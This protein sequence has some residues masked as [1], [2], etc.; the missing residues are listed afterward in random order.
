[1]TQESIALT[2]EEL[3]EQVWSKPVREVAAE[4]GI[5]DVGLAKACR[6]S[7]IPLPPQGYWISRHG[8]RARRLRPPLPAPKAG[9]QVHFEFH[10]RLAD[11]Q[12]D[13]LAER[14]ELERRLAALPSLD[15]L[16]PQVDR[17]VK[18]ARRAMYKRVDERGILLGSGELPW[19][20]RTSPALLERALGTL[21]GLLARLHGLGYA[22]F[23][24]RDRPDMAVVQIHGQEYWPWLEEH[25]HRSERALTAKEL[26][27]KKAAERERQYFYTPNRWVFKP[28]GH[29]TLKLDHAGHSY[30]RKQ[31][32]ERGNKKLEDKLDAIVIEI[33]E[34]ATEEKRAAELEVKRLAERQALEMQE[35]ERL[36][37][38]LHERQKRARLM[39]E[40]RAWG[41]AVRLHEY[42]DAVQAAPLSA[43][44]H[45]ETEVARWRWIK[46]ARNIAADLNPLESGSVGQQPPLPDLP[47][48]PWDWD[49]RY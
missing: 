23:P 25:S 44:Q 35:R 37:R 40:V 42:I 16:R 38:L 8:K 28:S 33:I 26:A 17:F 19:P 3:F 41:K 29:L 24:H 30:P 4:L 14:A 5:S 43:L 34:F 31:W 18:A 7:G 46:W 36:Q 48:S 11:S 1:M 6:R 47:E 39:R 10:P 20:V 12:P 45:L 13:S 2:R 32:G 21:A 27:D 9:Q 49:R 15:S 22:I